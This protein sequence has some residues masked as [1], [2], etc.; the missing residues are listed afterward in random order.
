MPRAYAGRGAS[1]RL[2]KNVQ[3]CKTLLKP[4]QKQWFLTETGV[5]RNVRKLR[6]PKIIGKP[7]GTWESMPATFAYND[8]QP[9]RTNSVHRKPWESARKGCRPWKDSAR[10]EHR[11]PMHGMLHFSCVFWILSTVFYR[12]S[13]LNK[14]K[15]YN[16][17]YR[18][19]TT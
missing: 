19:R 18:D 13:L 8:V 16:L 5:S 17:W 10:Q 9:G 2:V 12:K 4:I 11:E 15:T 7:L 3:K 6:F 14:R 1:S